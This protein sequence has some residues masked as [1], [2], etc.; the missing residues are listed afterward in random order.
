MLPGRGRRR[1]EQYRPW[2]Q[3]VIVQARARRCR[4]GVPAHYLAGVGFTWYGGCNSGTMTR[5]GLLD[6]LDA[7]DRRFGVGQGPGRPP[8][9]RA[10]WI[11]KHPWRA[12]LLYGLVLLIPKIILDVAWDSSGQSLAA[13]AFSIVV[14]LLLGFLLAGMVR[15]AVVKWDREHELPP[16]AG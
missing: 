2:R 11:A 13:V 9:R 8:N 10:R 5:M 16:G 7:I 15:N 4:A 1:P 12:G 6:R 3:L 14:S